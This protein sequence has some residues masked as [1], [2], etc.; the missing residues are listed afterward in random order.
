MRTDGKVKKKRKKK[1]KKGGSSGCER[2]E[3]CGC[4][5]KYL[6]DR[7]RQ[8]EGMRKRKKKERWG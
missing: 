4:N 7:E 1:L 5:S 6:K 3:I 2:E 8:G